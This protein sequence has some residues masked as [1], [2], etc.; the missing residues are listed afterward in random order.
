MILSAML[1]LGLSACADGLFQGGV[2]GPSIESGADPVPDIPV[3]E[4]SA[5]PDPGRDRAGETIASLGDP[6]D[7]GLWLRTPLVSSE[8]QG[9]VT[10]QN[11]ASVQLT[12]IP[13]A[14]DPGAGSQISL[15]A[16]QALNVPLT[17]LVTLTV[18][19]G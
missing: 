4:T 2:S 3:A 17:D 13:I 5:V 12:L 15:A 10:A 6:G 18:T 19:P 7:P 14:G 8:Q 11:G 1:V 9:L 16:M